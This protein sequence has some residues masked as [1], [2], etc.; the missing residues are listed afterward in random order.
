[1]EIKYKKLFIEII[2]DEN[3]YITEWDKQNIEEYSASKTMYCPKTY[4]VSGV[5]AI[6]QEEHDELVKQQE[7]IME[8]NREKYDSNSK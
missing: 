7:K 1:M 6:S 3:E 5:Y 8:E 2:A 4:D